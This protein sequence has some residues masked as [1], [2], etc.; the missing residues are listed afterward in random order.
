M[1][2]LIIAGYRLDTLLIIQQRNFNAKN[3]DTFIFSVGF[4]CVVVRSLIYLGT[5]VP[6]YIVVNRYRYPT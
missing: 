4:Q 3:T 6:R 5:Y 1:S 2:F